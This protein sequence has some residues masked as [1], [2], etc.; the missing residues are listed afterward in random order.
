MTTP[1]YPSR[2]A[3]ECALCARYRPGYA[4]PPEMRAAPVIDASALRQQSCGM[5]L[6]RPVSS[7]FSE[8]REELTA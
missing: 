2:K 8:A 1:C 4:L 7:P 6:A 5:F 3:L